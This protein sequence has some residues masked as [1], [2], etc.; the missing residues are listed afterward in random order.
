MVIGLGLDL[1]DIDRVVRMLDRDGERMTNR[2]LTDAEREYCFGMSKP[3]IHIAARV[4][5]K[6]ATFKALSGTTEARA[7]GWREIEVV[8]DAHRRP[9][10][11]LHGR[12][13]ARAMELGVVR[14]LLTLSHSQQTAGAVVLLERDTLERDS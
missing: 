12:A 11:V 13:R 2:I 7:I 5:A 4:A 6:E 9:E 3:A 14:V 10:L 1:V 8:H